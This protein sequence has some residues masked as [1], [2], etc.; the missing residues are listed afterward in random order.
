MPP[1]RPHPATRHG[2]GLGR[3]FWRVFVL[4][5]HGFLL[6]MLALLCAAQDLGWE[7]NQRAMF[8]LLLLAPLLMML[9]AIPVLRAPDRGEGP[10]WHVLAKGWAVLVTA[11][12]LPLMPLALLLLASALA[13]E[14]LP[15]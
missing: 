4:C 13:R 11:A 6:L 14:G 2:L 7:A 3:A 9:T 8:L 5:G 15:F 10:L 1:P 12:W